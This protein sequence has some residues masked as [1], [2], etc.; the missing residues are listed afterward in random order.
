[1]NV[2]TSPPLSTV[3]ESVVSGSGADCDVKPEQM[4]GLVRPATARRGVLDG[5]F[6]VL[7]ALTHANEGLGLTALARAS[8]LA[9]ASAHRLAEQLVALGAVQRVEHRYYVGARM[10][11]IGQ[12]WQPDPLLR[13]CAQ[14]PVHTLAVQS[15][16]AASL[17]I[18]HEQ[19]LRYVC[20]AVPHG[21]AYLPDPVDPESIARTATGRVLYA[22][23]PASDVT[24]P[25]CWT[26]REWRNLRE[27]IRDPR[28]TVIDHQDAVAGMCCVSA[29]VWW[30]DKACAGAVAVM[31][32]AD[33]LP[34]GL[35]SL[36]SYTAHRIGAALQQL[37][38]M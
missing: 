32:E 6:A 36:V 34:A 3:V 11:R 25:D 35:P 24:L 15:R 23:L 38:P 30:A 29:P 9:K 12:C 31:V 10:L 19:R 16:A 21:H 7:D 8:G 13:R 26:Q 33:D 4:A 18:L 1:M 20:A 17:R 5:A 28:T 27:S 37:K 14:A 22:T 2:S